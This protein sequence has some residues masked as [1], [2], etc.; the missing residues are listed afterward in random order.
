MPDADIALCVGVHCDVASVPE[1]PDILLVHDG[2]W[3][4]DVMIDFGICAKVEEVS[5]D[6]VE[7]CWD[8]VH[9]NWRE[10]SRVLRT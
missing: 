4:E 2:F 9:D 10:K 5:G 8:W 3:V 1:E 7:T 6:G